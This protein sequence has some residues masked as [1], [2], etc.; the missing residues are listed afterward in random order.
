MATRILIASCLALF[1]FFASTPIRAEAPSP[2]L[3]GRAFNVGV[4]IGC[5]GAILRER[6]HGV[7]VLTGEDCEFILAEYG[8]NRTM[9]DGEIDRCRKSTGWPSDCDHCPARARC[10][11]LVREEWRRHLG[12]EP[13]EE[14]E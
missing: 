9:T 7:G 1:L 6:E 13:P 2:G 11:E 3:V 5:Y 4:R 14:A 8:D 10:D 12:L